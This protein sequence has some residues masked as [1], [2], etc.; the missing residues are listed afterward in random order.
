MKSRGYILGSRTKLA[1]L[2]FLM[3]ELCDPEEVTY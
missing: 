3:Q 2:W 1:G